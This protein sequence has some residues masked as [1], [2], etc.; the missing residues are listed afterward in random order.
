MKLLRNTPDLLENRIPFLTVSGAT[1][2]GFFMPICRLIGD[3]KTAK[4]G[5]TVGGRGNSSGLGPMRDWLHDEG[6]KP[7]GTPHPMDLDKFQGWTLEQIE[8]RERSL[9]HEEMFVLDKDGNIIAAFKGG[10][11]SVSFPASLLFQDGVTVTHGHPKG[12]ENFGGTFSWADI[13]NMLNSNWAEHRATA[14]GQGEMNYIMRR[15]P[16]ADARGLR[17][18]IN[19]DYP[20]VDAQWQA[21][22]QKAYHEEIAKGTPQKQAM[23]IARQKGVGVLNAYYKRTFEK[24]GFEYITRKDPYHYGR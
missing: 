7:G 10:K 23:H 22:Y 11:H 4:G 15:T 6:G 20:R 19:K 3:S 1:T 12:E 13:D 24:Y 14:S 5:W 2:G 9:A 16:K 8:A 21:A 18:Q 17:N